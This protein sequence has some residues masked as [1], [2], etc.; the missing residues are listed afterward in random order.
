M[1]SALR[2]SRGRGSRHV[3]PPRLL[4]FSCQM[5]GNPDQG[6]ARPQWSLVP[7]ASVVARP[8]RFARMG[9]SSSVL[10]VTTMRSRLDRLRRQADEAGVAATIVSPG[11]D[12][13]YLPGITGPSFGRVPPLG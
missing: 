13:R 1:A 2:K 7:L 9:V 8:G 6:R 5:T 10:D 3:G 11:P 12:L 4:S